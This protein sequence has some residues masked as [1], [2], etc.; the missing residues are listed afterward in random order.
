MYSISFGAL[1]M[2]YIVGD[3]FHFQMQDFQGN[4]I[5]NP[6]LQGVGTATINAIGVNSTCITNTCHNAAVNPV[7]YLAVAAAYAWD[8]FML[9]AGLQIFNYMAILGAPLIFLYMFIGLY[10]FLLVRSMMGWIRGI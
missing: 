1:G 10:L 3:V 9:I 7:S 8:I 2:Q 5:K 4:Q 6:V